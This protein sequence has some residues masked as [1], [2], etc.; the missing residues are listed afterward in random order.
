MATVAEPI[1]QINLL[2]RR[3]L[4]G[5]YGWDR[6]LTDHIIQII[7]ML[8]F[9]AGMTSEPEV[10]QIWDITA[11]FHYF[12]TLGIDNP[13]ISAEAYATTTCAL[14]NNVAYGVKNDV[15]FPLVMYNKIQIPGS[16]RHGAV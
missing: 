6:F 9:V 5:I 14:N 10:L 12:V 2:Y 15:A 16:E 4:T 13:A 1:Q 3:T 7:L 11:F 8:Y